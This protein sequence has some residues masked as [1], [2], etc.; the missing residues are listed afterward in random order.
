[1]ADK[2][3]LARDDD[4]KAYMVSLLT[5]RPVLQPDGLVT[6]LD[7]AAECLGVYSAERAEQLFG[8][9]LQHGECVSGRLSF[10]TVGRVANMQRQTTGP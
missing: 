1:M 2:V 5:D 8:V 9:K 7:E 6:T 10:Q 4:G 3:W